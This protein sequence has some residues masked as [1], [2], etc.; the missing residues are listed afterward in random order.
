MGVWIAFLA[1]DQSNFTVS[2]SGWRSGS[3][4]ISHIGKN[5]AWCFSFISEM[6][7]S[8][9][10]HL[11]LPA[12]T[13]VKPK[14]GWSTAHWW[15][16][17]EWNGTFLTKNSSLWKWKSPDFPPW[18]AAR[19]NKPSLKAKCPVFAAGSSSRPTQ[20]FQMKSCW[21][22]FSLSYSHTGGT[23]RSRHHTQSKTKL[24]ALE[25]K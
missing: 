20:E 1:L 10:G 13:D 12:V 19:L 11:Q 6:I 24:N 7:S 16:L 18:F 4:L 21:V 3:T 23:E 25:H 15:R 22:F 2:L 5:E 8:N 9:V 17:Y 14:A